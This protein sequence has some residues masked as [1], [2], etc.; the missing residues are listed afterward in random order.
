MG[1]S[2]EFYDQIVSTEVQNVYQALATHDRL[3]LSTPCF[4]RRNE[5]RIQQLNMHGPVEYVT[6]ESWFPGAHYDIGRQRFVGARKA[7]RFKRAVRFLNDC[8]V[9]GITVRPT[10]AFADEPLHWM[11]ENVAKHDIG[12]A[13]A[14]ARE[15]FLHPVMPPDGARAVSLLRMLF[16]VILRFLSLKNI[17]SWRIEIRPELSINAY[18]TLVTRLPPWL[19]SFKGLALQDRRVPLDRGANFRGICPW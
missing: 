17:S 16:T 12:M 10:D 6:E 8:N 19:N 7:G 1:L 14:N 15:E 2:Y 9:F 3:K 5:N 4:A 18:D 11:L 13:P